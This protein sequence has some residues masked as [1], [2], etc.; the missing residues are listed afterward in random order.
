MSFGHALYYPYINLTNKNWLKHAFLFWDKISRI[1]PYSIR[2]SDSEEIIKIKY[3]TRFINDYSPNS[4]VISDTFKAFSEYLERIMDTEDFYRY[5]RMRYRDYFEDWEDEHWRRFREDFGFRRNILESIVKSYGTYLHVEKIH[6]K[7]KEKL[8]ALGLAI[9]GEKEY[10]DWIKIDKE[11]DFIYMTYLAK[12]ISKEKTIPIVTDVEE[13]YSASI[14]FEPKLFRD[15]KSEFEYKLG[16]LLIG[17]F[18]PKDINSVPFDKLIE[19]RKKYSAERINF[20]NMISNLCQSLPEID[21]ESALK[22][23]LNH[24]KES[25]IEQTKELKNIYESFKIETVC[26]FLNISVPSALV[27]ISDII[28]IPYKSLGIGAGIIFGLV[29]TVASVKKEKKQ[30]QERP[31]SYLLNISSELSGE[32]IFRKIND[33]V[34]G[35]RKWKIGD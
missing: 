22:D 26:K 8:F 12:S 32:D 11:I 9:P 15:Y 34:K 29:S 25:L 16:N 30:L 17:C 14:L 20:F 13:F 4:W 18:L 28:P 10:K 1:V 35:L 2:P 19:I 27:S 6:E 3:E 21:N 23:A 24:Y 5:Y 31:L 33:A 7:L